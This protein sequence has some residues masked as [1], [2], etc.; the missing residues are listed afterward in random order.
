MAPDPCNRGEKILV[1]YIMSRVRASADHVRSTV[2]TT[3]TD[4]S[5]TTAQ[6]VLT[7][8]EQPVFNRYTY[9]GWMY[10]VPAAAA[11]FGCLFGGL[12]FFAY[13]R[14][15]RAQRLPNSTSFHA[16]A[17][18]SRQ[19]YAAL[20]RSPATKTG[21]TVTPSPVSA[22]ATA[23][24]SSNGIVQLKS[25]QFTFFSDEIA[26]QV[27][28][29][30]TVALALLVGTTTSNLMYDIQSFHRD[31]AKVPLQPGA[32]KLCHHMCPDILQQRE[33]LLSMSSLGQVYED[34]VRQQTLPFQAK[35]EL[36]DSEGRPIN[37]DNKVVLVGIPQSFFGETVLQLNPK[38]LWE[39][40]T[41]EDLESMVILVESC[42]RRME[43]E[44]E[45][46]RRNDPLV[47]E[48]TGLV[49]IPSPGVPL[50]YLKV[51][52]ESRQQRER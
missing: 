51:D 33:K 17:T 4:R 27:Q 38:E 29:I 9:Y 8:A 15:I 41:T 43:F 25:D 34:H 37:D 24:P 26:V 22:A 11:T 49:T 48:P 10:G 14:W 47:D 3:T 30:V 5:T 20:D 31:L 1:S 6:L 52:E 12:R 40:P 42:R 23:A 2:D 35:S 21:T 18:A 13:R 32:S 7:E 16:R 39:N 45:C 36:A 46:R 19:H 50:R 44:D 28:L